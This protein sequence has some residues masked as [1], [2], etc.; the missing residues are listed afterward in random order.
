MLQR[1]VWRFIYDFDTFPH[2]I[3]VMAVMLVK[4][5]RALDSIKQEEEDDAADVVGVLKQHAGPSQWSAGCTSSPPMFSR[6]LC[7]VVLG[8]CRYIKPGM[9]RRFLQLSSQHSRVQVLSY[10][11]AKKSP[12]YNWKIVTSSQCCVFTIKTILF[13]FISAVS[14]VSSW[15][16][17]CPAVI[18]VALISWQGYHL[19]LYKFQ[20]IHPNVNLKTIWC[21]KSYYLP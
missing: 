4:L 6:S 11:A 17:G 16:V 21:V 15:Q 10:S 7:L 9:W 2:S 14:K 18:N 1:S 19:W 20:Q 13:E 5:F 8:R 12:L 3:E